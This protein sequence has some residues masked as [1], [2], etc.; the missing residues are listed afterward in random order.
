MDD[1]QLR[2]F[3]KGKIEQS[4]RSL[5]K[6]QENAKQDSLKRQ[7]TIMI[8][9]LEKKSR[10][11]ENYGN[12]ASSRDKK[13]YDEELSTFISMILKITKDEKDVAPLRE[14][15]KEIEKTLNS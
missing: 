14:A 9:L 13:Y 8:G 3:V 7:I 10:P 12:L 11:L 1:E 4:I 5:Y 2:E 15:I 6:K